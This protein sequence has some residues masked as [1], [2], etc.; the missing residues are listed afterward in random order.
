MGSLGA[1]VIGG[2]IGLVSGLASAA[3]TQHYSERREWTFKAR[4]ER[5]SAYLEFLTELDVALQF[6]DDVERAI[7]DSTGVHAFGPQGDEGP[8]RTATEERLR[9]L[10]ERADGVSDQA[11][12]AL[13]RLQLVAGQPVYIAALEPVS[14]VTLIKYDLRQLLTGEVPNDRR[15]KLIPVNSRERGHDDV[16]AA[17]REDLAR[18]WLEHLHGRSARRMRTGAA[19]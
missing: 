10:M 12:R 11:R 8:T 5:R 14:K 15:F 18:P 16:V 9:S 2:L 7:N 6:L 19:A 4:D 13:N 17:M 1:V 3:L